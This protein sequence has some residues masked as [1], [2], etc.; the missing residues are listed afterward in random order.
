MQELGLV[1]LPSIH[2]PVRFADTSSTA[3]LELPSETPGWMILP[4]RSLK[5]GAAQGCMP[6]YGVYIIT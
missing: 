5:V 4:D 2:Q 3:S 6:T 1:L